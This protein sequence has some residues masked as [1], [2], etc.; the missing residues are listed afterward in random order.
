M[1]GPFRCSPV[2]AFAVALV[3]ALLPAAT[4]TVAFG[5]VS[6]CSC[7]WDQVNDSTVYNFLRGAG[8]NVIPNVAL[9]GQEF[10]PGQTSLDLVELMVNAQDPGVAELYVRI[11]ETSITGPAAKSS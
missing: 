7:S 3:A 2:R 8:G 5:Q 10:V 11:R 6:N 4:G 1:Q 9:V